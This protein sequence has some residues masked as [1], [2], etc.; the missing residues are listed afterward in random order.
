VGDVSPKIRPTQGVTVPPIA[1]R[2][3]LTNE[4][5]AASTEGWTERDE[6]CTEACM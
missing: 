2:G 4:A 1:G 6:E 3:P 5:R